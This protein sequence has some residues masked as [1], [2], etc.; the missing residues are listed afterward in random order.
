MNTIAIFGVGL[1]GGSFGLA[2]KAA[3]F[4]GRILGVSR[5]ATLEQALA[6]GAI[7]EGVTFEAA[8]GRADLLYLA[9]PVGLIIEA[10]PRLAALVQPQALVTDAGSTKSDISAA[11][12]QH[13][14]P[15]QFLGGHPMAGKESRGI[16][17]ADPKL[18]QNSTYFVTPDLQSDWRTPPV[19]SFLSWVERLGAHPVVV[20][21]QEH[22]RIVA[23]TSHLPQ[24]ASTALALALARQLQNEEH[25]HFCGSG[26]RDSLRLAQSPYG[27]WGDILRTNVL[28]VS[29]ALEQYILALEDLKECLTS[30]TMQERFRTANDIAR[31][32]RNQ[33]S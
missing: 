10:I 7:D 6:R 3:G 12:R 18:F 9:L 15:G 33:V 5:P 4:P 28:E 1:I 13:L 14:P 22:D 8:A 26:L 23:V 2:M 20:D 31:R 16:E 19:S 32:L 24:L 17:S 29:R 30:D 25:Q 27:V 11:G 21:A